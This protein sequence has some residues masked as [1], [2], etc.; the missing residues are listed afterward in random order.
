MT[1]T[2]IQVIVK[3]TYCNIPYEIELRLNEIKSADK[4]GVLMLQTEQFIDKMLMKEPLNDDKNR[5]T[6]TDLKYG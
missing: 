6:E 1:E 2:G 3:R 4:V 5:Q